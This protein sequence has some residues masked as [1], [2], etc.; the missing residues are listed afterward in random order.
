MG[1]DRYILGVEGEHEQADQGHVVA[2]VDLEA[3]D[4]RLGA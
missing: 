3:L 1:L 4:Q 2:G